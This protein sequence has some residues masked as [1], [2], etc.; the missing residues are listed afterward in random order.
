M[1]HSPCSCLP[2]PRE[3]DARKEWK[4]AKEKDEDIMGGGDENVCV[5]ALH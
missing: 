2:S 4:E 3:N 5:V 1:H